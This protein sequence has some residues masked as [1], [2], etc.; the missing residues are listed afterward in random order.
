LS[1]LEVTFPVKRS[2]FSDF[3]KEAEIVYRPFEVKPIVTG[4]SSYSVKEYEVILEGTGWQIIND[5][6]KA[7]SWQNNTVQ[8][9]VQGNIEYPISTHI[10]QNH[11]DYPVRHLLNED[12]RLHFNIG[13]LDIAV[14]REELG[15]DELTIKNIKHKF[16]Q[17][18]NDIQNEVNKTL[19]TYNTKYEAMQY[20]SELFSKTRCLSGFE[21]SYKDENISNTAD[22]PEGTQ[23]VKYVR[24]KYYNN[25]IK[26]KRETIGDMHFS[27]KYTIPKSE[28]G[29]IYIFDD[30]NNETKAV[31]KA[32]SIISDETQ[33]VI[34]ITHDNRCLLEILGYP[35]VKLTSDIALKTVQKSISNLK[36][37]KFRSW[38][39]Y[40]KNWFKTEYYDINTDE[41]FYYVP[42]FNSEYKGSTNLHD[43]NEI[44]VSYNL[45]TDNFYGLNKTTT[46]S[47]IFKELQ[48]SGIAKEFTSEMQKKIKAH[49]KF[50]EDAEAIKKYKKHTALI[51]KAGDILMHLINREGFI[52]ECMNIPESDR[53]SGI[54]D[55]IKAH[56]FIKANEY[57][58]LSTVQYYIQSIIPI[59]IHEES[60]E[61][62]M[63]DMS[64]YAL[65]KGLDFHASKVSFREIIEY[66][67][68]VHSVE[69]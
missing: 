32:R 46:E 24:D 29:T 30:M 35:E 58:S 33:E 69:A 12:F 21:Y 25:K 57:S 27:D 5:T 52:N 7:Y 56:D 16:I 18:Q 20:L 40:V 38:S 9:A 65:L 59:E 51:H 47:K 31:R 19:E 66:I 50:K 22:I 3:R 1:G 45:N 60:E 41:E 61:L 23:L 11:L 36:G 37:K 14:S 42:L 55:I 39:S 44:L 26:I 63:P 15:Y 64:K 49:E 48:A 2:D 6:S 17:I 43:M 68:L 13:E 62:Q 8:V 10:I 53:S 54:K 34:L 28:K 67:D 4:N